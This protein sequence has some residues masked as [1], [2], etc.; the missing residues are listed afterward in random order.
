MVFQ[1][2]ISRLRNLASR[3]AKTHQKRV[4]NQ[5]KHKQQ[6]TQTARWKHEE[7]QFNLNAERAM[8]QQANSSK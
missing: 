3:K 4:I 8:E 5:Q 6:E 7:I 1:K 2:A